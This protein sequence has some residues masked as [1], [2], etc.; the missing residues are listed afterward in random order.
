[1]KTIVVV[2]PNGFIRATAPASVKPRGRGA[3]RGAS[4]IPHSGQAYELDIPADIMGLGAS[5][6]HRGYRVDLRGTPKLM[7]IET[8]P[9]RGKP[10][11]KA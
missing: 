6:L 3:P 11:A 2:D 5:E 4:M 7:K 9:S 8:A 1:M 10:P